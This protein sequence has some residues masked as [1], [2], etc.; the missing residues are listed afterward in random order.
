MGEMH[1]LGLLVGDCAKFPTPECRFEFD[2]EAA[3]IL[4]RV[5]ESEAGRSST[6]VGRAIREGQG[7]GKARSETKVG[8]GRAKSAPE[9]TTVGFVARSSPKVF[10][11]LSG[12]NGAN[13]LLDGFVARVHSPPRKPRASI[14]ISPWNNCDFDGFHLGELRSTVE[15]AR[16]VRIRRKG[17]SESCATQHPVITALWLRDGVTSQEV[18]FRPRGACCFFDRVELFDLREPVPEMLFEFL[19]LSP[20]VVCECI[21]RAFVMYTLIRTGIPVSGSTR[22][23]L[24]VLRPCLP[25]L[26][27]HRR[28]DQTTRKFACP[29]PIACPVR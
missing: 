25:G 14:S 20:E 13:R 11:F 1:L 2:D 17:R 28:S 8:V 27:S 6:A 9:S 7:M 19:L 5:P 10:R 12:L 29:P 24:P 23:H 15:S 3:S 18:A 21:A 22:S 26:D 4:F 16:C